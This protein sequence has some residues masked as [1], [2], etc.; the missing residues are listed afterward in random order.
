[1]WGW[2]G[3]VAGQ[4]NLIALQFSRFQAVNSDFFRFPIDFQGEM[5]VRS[6]EHPEWASVGSGEWWLV[7]IASD[8]DMTGRV[9]V[10]GKVSIR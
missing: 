6:A 8:V 2:R 7:G 4:R 1:M 9:E 10:R 5:F 3:R